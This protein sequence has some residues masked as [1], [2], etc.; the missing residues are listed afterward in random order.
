MRTILFRGKRIDNGEWVTGSGVVIVDEDYVAI[1]KTKDVTSADY[2][3]KLVKIVPATVGEFI[4][5][6][7]KDGNKIFDGDI[8][9]IKAKGL[10]WITIVRWSGTASKYEGSYLSPSG[11]WLDDGLHCDANSFSLHTLIGNIHDN[12]ELVN[13]PTGGALNTMID[14]NV[15]TEQEEVAAPAEQAT[16]GTESAETEG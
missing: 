3:I 2:A 15:K 12:P 5:R 1:P 11:V 9:Q 14:P 8:L 7:D 10:E 13:Q 16:E 6:K 4:D